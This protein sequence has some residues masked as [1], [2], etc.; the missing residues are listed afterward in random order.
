MEPVREDFGWT[1]AQ[2][3]WIIT[4]YWIVSGFSSP[5]IGRLIDIHGA[6][7]VM[8]FTAT[9]NGVSPSKG[10]LPVVISYRITPRA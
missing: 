10:I 1:K 3:T 2:V 7:K 6:R 4:I 9:L 8:L 5:I